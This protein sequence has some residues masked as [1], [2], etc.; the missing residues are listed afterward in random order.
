MILARSE[1]KVLPLNSNHTFQ[2]WSASAVSASSSERRKQW[3]GL[4]WVIR[5]KFTTNTIPPE[6]GFGKYREELVTSVD[7][8]RISPDIEVKV[9]KTLMLRGYEGRDVSAVVT[10]V[11]ENS[12]KLDANHPLAG[13]ELKFAIELLEVVS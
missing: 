4:D 9:G 8:S 3:H 11:F 5:L 7:K 10:D 2:S 12:V 6:D 13:E 1:R